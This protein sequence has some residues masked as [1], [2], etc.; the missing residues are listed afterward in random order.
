MIIAPLPSLLNCEEY[1]EGQIVFL[2][3]DF[4]LVLVGF[5]GCGRQ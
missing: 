1:Y 2:V 5:P 4:K 3:I